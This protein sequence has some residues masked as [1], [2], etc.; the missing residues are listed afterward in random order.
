M[1]KFDWAEV[2]QLL[3]D[4]TP[5]LTDCGRLCKKKCCSLEESGRG[6]FLFPGEDKL[7][8]K[9]TSWCR[10]KGYTG[11]NMHYTGSEPL[12]LDCCG[13]CPRDK[14]PLVC[15]LFPMAPYLNREGSLE[16][17]FDPDAY[18]ICP[19]S[20]LEDYE[21]LNKHFLDRVRQVWLLLME[22]EEIVE[23]VKAY[24][25]RLDIEAKEP[26]KKLLG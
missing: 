9:E 6:V 14:R 21:V 19:L 24:S 2:Y 25:Q 22:D 3:E 1:K 7:F 26:W 4:V 15:R 23:N 17:I 20:R 18:F 11:D 16:I 13:R 8:A 12:M 10:V 5:L